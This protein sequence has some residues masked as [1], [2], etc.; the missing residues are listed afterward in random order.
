MRRRFSVVVALVL[1]VVSGLFV[2]AANP[3]V[4]PS[5]KWTSDT[6]FSGGTF[7]A[8]RVV[9]TGNGASIQLGVNP[10][11]NW[12]NM[13]PSGAPSPRRGPVMTFDSVHNVILVF[14]GVLPSG[15]TN[16]LWTYDTVSNTWTNITPGTSPPARWKAGF[17]YDTLQQV[18]A[19]V[20]GTRATRTDVE[21]TKV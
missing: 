20:L 3:V 5:Q 12:V 6:D 8:T 21:P 2:F 7:L 16:D 14:G 11:Q 17:S 10:T 13:A 9:G 1:L 19:R 4:A 15:Y 18:A